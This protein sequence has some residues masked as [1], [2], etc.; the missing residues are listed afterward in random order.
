MTK[1]IAPSN[2]RPAPVSTQN[3]DNLFNGRVFQWPAVQA[4]VTVGK[5]QGTMPIPFPGLP[6][7]PTFPYATNYLSPTINAVSGAPA[8]DVALDRIQRSFRV[9]LDWHMLF[10]S[11]FEIGTATGFEHIRRPLE[12]STGIGL[13]GD[14]NPTQQGVENLAKLLNVTQ[15]V[16]T[17]TLSFK[18]W[19][20]SAKDTLEFDDQDFSTPEKYL[21]MW[22]EKVGS[23]ILNIDSECTVTVSSLLAGEIAARFEQ[24]KSE[25]D[26][27][28]VFIEKADELLAKAVDSNG[29][30]NS[31]RASLRRAMDMKVAYHEA[32]SR[33]RE[34]QK[35]AESLGYKLDAETG[36]IVQ[37]TR[38]KTSYIPTHHA[39]RIEKVDE[40]GIET[41]KYK[42]INERPGRF[43]LEP[44]WGAKEYSL[45]EAL[46]QAV[47]LREGLFER[48]GSQFF[49]ATG[50]SLDDVLSQLDAWAINSTFENIS[51][52]L[53]DLGVNTGEQLTGVITAYR[54]QIGRMP[55]QLPS[56][57]I[58]EKYRMVLRWCGAAVGEVVESITLAPGEERTLVM[59]RSTVIERE[60]RT[61]ATS[62]LDIASESKGEFVSE[63][64]AESRRSRDGT[65]SSNWSAATSGGANW[66]IFNASGQA[67][68]G[69]TWNES[70]TEFA[71]TLSKLTQKAASSLTART[72]Y[73]VSSMA[74]YKATTTTRDST[75]VSFKNINQ[76][77]A[78]T[79][80]LSQ[81]TNRYARELYLSELSVT[82]HPCTETLFAA[83]FALPRQF[84]LGEVNGIL[85]AMSP[86]ALPIHFKIDKKTAL[87]AYYKEILNKIVASL[88]QYNLEIEGSVEKAIECLKAIEDATD[89]ETA[90]DLAENGFRKLTMG[91]KN[92]LNNADPVDG[93]CAGLFMTTVPSPSTG[94]EEYTNNLRNVELERRQAENREILARAQ[95]MEAI[96]NSI[97]AK[98]PELVAIVRKGEN[99]QTAEVS[100]IG[101]LLVGTWLLLTD[102]V[103]QITFEVKDK[104]ILDYKLEFESEQPWLDPQN[105]NIGALFHP[106]SKL[107]LPF[108]V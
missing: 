87:A 99:L 79:L 24:L 28:S 85:K 26:A 57:F 74:S 107:S 76:G 46:S 15:G 42:V 39:S 16:K 93:P 52:P 103:V 78:L 41:Y 21:A 7:I 82:V 4:E 49:A 75:T 31:Y 30:D 51:I 64:E 47:G 9:E 3:P 12:K 83:E 60:T 68:G 35:K 44:D 91:K 55:I 17:R 33:M 67:A 72:R 1:E 59:E 84:A 50:Q 96:A 37:L 80:F 69:Q 8:E 14:G 54:P 2:S 20:V 29:L 27:T 22:R 43:K 92:L 104:S 36:K 108:V 65:H 23:V 56:L 98:P 62:S 5:N 13:G 106:D 53:Y 6:H 90:I 73:E 48:R 105:R 40:L 77:C 45:A 32:R 34:L 70:T 10:S 25:V 102:G 58:E 97:V 81:L 94:L 95:Q 86:E 11:A 101:V 100:F 71:K 89:V 38:L 61:T 88:Y 19:N 18:N 63:V 66:G